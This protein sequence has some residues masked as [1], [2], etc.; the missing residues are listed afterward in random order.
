MGAEA[1]ARLAGAVLLAACLL[2]AL[3]ADSTLLLP[4]GL[5]L[6]G[7]GWNVALMAGS[8]LL[9]T[10]LSRQ[11]RPRRE[12]LGEVGAGAG[13]AAA[14]GGAGSGVL[15][16]ASGYSA[17]ALGAAALSVPLLFVVSERRRAAAGSRAT[18]RDPH[19]TTTNKGEI[20]T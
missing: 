3:A 2:A 16:A 8:V 15:S 19:D 4:I 17:V 9:T 12:G 6:V 11:A 14:V 13:A 18:T 5:L 7:V 1:T 10:G 20:T